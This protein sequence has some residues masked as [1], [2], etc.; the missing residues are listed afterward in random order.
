VLGFLNLLAT[1][2]AELFEALLSMGLSVRVHHASSARWVGLST[3][4]LTLGLCG[5][6][7]ALVSLGPDAALIAPQWVSLDLPLNPL[8]ESEQHGSK[9]QLP[10]L[11]AQASS[12]SNLHLNNENGLDSA[13]SNTNPLNSDLDAL[14]SNSGAP[15]STN[16]LT[17]L[18]DLQLNPLQLSSGFNIFKSDWSRTS[19][20]ANSL[21]SRLEVLDSEANRFLT[22]NPLVRQNL[23]GKDA[24]LV[25]VNTNERHQLNQLTAKWI[26]ADPDH[27]QRLVI[28]RNAL[29]FTAR[30]QTE[31]LTV[32]TQVAGATIQ[33]SLFQ[34]TDQAKIPDAI[35]NQ[36]VDIFSGDIDFH[37]ALKK[38]DHFSLV[39]EVFLADGETLKTGRILSAEFS[40]R[41]HTYQAVWFASKKS[42]KGG[43]Y[44]SM[45]GKNLRRTF[46]A[47]PLQFSRI[48][49][50]FTMRMHPILQTWKAHLGID[51]AAPIGTP[52]KSVGDG[53]VEFAGSQNGYGNVIFVQHPQ[54]PLTVYAHLSSIRVHK[55]Q[56]VLQG[57]AIGLVGQ[58][59]WA[60]GPHLHFEFR[61]NGQHQ[62]PLMLAKQIDAS[63]VAPELRPQFNRV[64]YSAQA[65]LAKTQNL[66]TIDID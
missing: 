51:Y 50:G 55:G 22:T 12:K 43:D 60:T 56:R 7:Y 13:E 5:A 45:D 26:G 57:D 6:S 4:I 1:L 62:D 9:L 61:L 37:R 46:L 41:A 20:N 10:V 31:P 23:L 24:R 39:Y 66:D 25:S 17:S 34:A 58:T 14:G 52:V 15:S 54:G 42:P 38:G 32:S 11:N 19:D 65:A 8:F 33:S 59:G 63:P 18:P 30:L 3:V 29:G 40:T 48:S 53:I 2:L 28:T 36:M 27:F 21:L 16:A 35:A 44:Y 47:A 64:A 49:S